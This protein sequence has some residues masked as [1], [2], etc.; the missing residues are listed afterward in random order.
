MNQAIISQNVSAAL[1]EDLGSGDITAALISTPQPVKAFIHSREAAVLCG[2]PWVNEVFRQ[3]DKG[4]VITWQVADG[5]QIKANTQIC[6]LTGP[7]RALL[8]G[9]RCAI[10]F[11]QTLSGTAAITRNFVTQLDGTKTQLLDT[12][13]TLP[14]LRYAQKYA[15][16]CGGGNNHRHGLYDAYLIKENH[17]TACGSINKAI[18]IARE[19]QPDKLV[20]IEVE[21]IAQLHQALA[22][23]ADIIM[24]DNF[25]IEMISAAV[26]INNGQAKLE[27][28]GNVD[29]NMIRELAK[30][31]IDYISVGALTKHVQAI[32]F[33]MRLGRTV[34]SQQLV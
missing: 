1:T 21:T 18:A 34:C 24:L 19:L 7:A 32:D 20:E 12:R 15:V 28:S 25:D 4:I 10:N 8:T 17:I 29:L 9:E 14:G 23:K 11:L 31:G 3:L 2:I 22:A 6:Q 16:K 26:A 27:V 33:S 30:T 5:D 13:K